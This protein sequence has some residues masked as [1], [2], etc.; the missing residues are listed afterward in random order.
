MSS[1]LYANT[2]QEIGEVVVARGAVSV[3]S[4][5]SEIRILGK[6][7][8]IYLGDVITTEAKSFAVIKMIDGARFSVRPASVFSFENYSLKENDEN[9]VMRL[10]KGGLR[11]ISGL[12]S[13]KNPDGF[14]LNTTV[15]TIG[16]RGTEFDA[17]LCNVDCAIENQENKNKVAPVAKIAFLNGEVSAISKDNQTRELALSVPVFEGDTIITG[18]GSYVVLAFNDKSR[19]SLKAETEIKIEKHTYISPDSDK[20]NAAYSLFKGG[21][22]ALTGLI[23]KKKKDNYKLKTPTATI[24]IRGTGYDLVWLGPCIGGASSCG[25]QGTVW[26]G[27]IFVENEA[28]EFELLE[29]QAFAVRFGNTPLIII[30]TPP[31]LD[32]PRP[33]QVDI[34]FDELFSQLTEDVPSGLY[35]NTRDG[36][37]YLQRDGQIIEMTPGQ[38]GFV[39]TDGTV[40]VKLDQPKLF[41]TND[42]YLQ[43]I[44]EEF[45]TFFNIFDDTGFNQ[46]EF[47]CVM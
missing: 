37:V 19:M 36:T 1:K 8:P 20:N 14:K 15:A 3:K 16:I 22:R 21:I 13:K 46:T 2:T 42:P 4:A 6:A 9:A 24:G 34:N 11:A 33:D 23:S 41:Q 44:N 27:A 28:G 38:G 32:I 25:L 10:F 45:E 39:S 26:Q 5:D 30:T 31:I 43:M 35:V 18:K 12:I 17:R 29:N 40:F 47:E 7:D